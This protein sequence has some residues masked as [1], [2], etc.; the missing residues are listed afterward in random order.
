MIVKCF[1]KATQGTKV[2]PV[3]P[4]VLHNIDLGAKH[5]F[6][7]QSARVQIPPPLLTCPGTG[8]AALTSKIM[9]TA[10]GRH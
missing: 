6:L 2:G 7:Y 1:T 3:F 8:A 10:T 4:I 9:L 5:R